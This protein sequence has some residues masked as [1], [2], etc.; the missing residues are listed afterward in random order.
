LKQQADTDGARG[1]AAVAREED[2][3]LEAV[4]AKLWSGRLLI[5]AVVVVFAIG[6]FLVSVLMTPVFRA[7]TVLVDATADRSAMG[8]LSA[9]LG[10]LG[11]LA[12]LAGIN[13][14]NTG[15]QVEESIAVLASREFTEKFISDNNLLPKLF[16][17]RYDAATGKFV[18]DE[19]EWPTLADAYA[20]FNEDIRFISR[21]RLSGLITLAIEWRDPDEAARWAN[22]LVERLNQEMR[23]RAIASSTASVGY[24]EKEL[25]STG[26]IE[27]RQAITRLME[28]Q[29][30]QRMLANVTVEFAFRVADRA[31]PPDERK[32][33]R[34]RKLTLISV[35]VVLGL[36][37]GVTL[38]LARAT[39]ARKHTVGSA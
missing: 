9:A 31:M 34:P 27:T 14:G 3:E 4:V 18:G 8:G 21:D 39:F 22:L 10:Q 16:A 13:L 35:S 11:G 15:S 19:E 26:V 33:V 17:D 24:L 23:A 32:P 29:I 2:V 30:N 20:Y 1:E 5:T 28:A 38:V 25:A 6:G 37:L 36:I 12:S 7:Q